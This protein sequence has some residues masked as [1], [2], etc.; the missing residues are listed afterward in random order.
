MKD[1]YYIDGRTTR[2]SMGLPVYACYASLVIHFG[3]ILALFAVK[4]KA[5]E[6]KKRSGIL[7]CILTAFGVLICQIIF[8][9]ILVT[10][11][12]PVIM[13][14]GFYINIEDPAKRRLENYNQEV[15]A[16]F[17]TLVENRDGSTGDH[18]RRTSGYVEILLRAMRRQPAY[19]ALITR[20]YLMNVKNAAPMHDIGKIAIPDSIL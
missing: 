6:K 7:M 2:Y 4:Y 10:S 13:V 18:I 16:G 9:E 19:R 12:F 5:I 11:L 3:M 1:L 17:A 15:V 8:P 20:D 14:L